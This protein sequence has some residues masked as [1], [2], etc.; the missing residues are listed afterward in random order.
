[1]FSALLKFELRHWFR[2]VAFYAYAFLLCLLAMLTVAGAGGIF[3]EGSS[4]AGIANAPVRLYSYALIFQKLLF[5]LLPAFVGVSLHRDYSSKVYS[6]LYTYPFSKKEYLPAK[7]IGGFLPVLVLAGL[8]LFGFVLG[9]LLPGV[10]LGKTAPFDGYAYAQLFLAYLA[11][12]LFLASVLVFAVVAI[13]RNV[14]AGFIT[15]LLLLLIREALV[16]LTGGLHADMTGVLADP[17]GET[18]IEQLTLGWSPTS[19]D[20]QPIP[21][22]P[23][24]LLNRLIWTAAALLGF[25]AI[26]RRFSFSLPDSSARKESRLASKRPPPL[27]DHALYGPAS[28]EIRL[29]FSLLNRL[30]TAWY[31]ARSDLR[32]ILKSG[33]FLSILVTGAL[34]IGVILLQKNPQTDTRLLPVTWNVLGIPMLFVTLLIQGLT[35][36]YAGMLVQRARAADMHVLIDVTPAPNWVFSLS[37]FLALAKMQMVLLAL[38]MATGISIQLYLG[39]PHLEPGHYLFDLIVI[40]L[41]GLLLWAVAAL[42]VQTLFT[43]PYLGLFVLIL[44]AAGLEKLSALGI[45]S[46]LFQFNQTPAPH[47]FLRYSDL[48][49]HDHGLASHLVY[50]G[51]WALFGVLLGFA[52]LVFWQRALV[53]SMS[54][55]WRLAR[56]QFN[57]R[58][59]LAFF[60]F[61]AGFLLVGTLLFRQERQGNNRQLSARE[62]KDYLEKFKQRFGRY[63]HTPQPRITALFF[64]MDLFP[65][66][67]CFQASGYFT[68]VNKS[69]RAMDTLL[70]RTGYDEITTLHLPGNTRL[71]DAD[72]VLKFGV[73]RLKEALFPGDSLCI[74]FSLQS[75]PNTML[76]RHSGVLRN[77]TH[78]KN[79]IFPRLGYFAE[80]EKANP[81]YPGVRDRHYQGLDAD[82][83]E[84]EATISTALSQTVIAPGDLDSS[85]TT[86][87]RR[88]FHFR[89]D[90]TIKYV[91]SI[92]SGEY[93]VHQENYNGVDLRIHHYPQHTYC[94]S[95][96]MDGLK[97]ALDYNTH[98]FG[99]YQHRQI[100]IVEF[101][102]SEGTYATTAANCIPISE[103]RFINDT[104]NAS[105][106]GVDIAFYVAGH[107]LTHQWWGNQVI[108]A[109]AQGALMLTES[110]TEYITAKLYERQYGKAQAMHFLDL[111]RNRYRMGRAQETQP[112]PALLFVQPEQSYL[113]YGKGALV[114][115]ALSESIG[116]HNLNAALCDFL[117]R[118]RFR[119]PP[120]PTSTDLYACLKS[121]TPDSLHN[122]LA[123]LFLSNHTPGL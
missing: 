102:R 88:Y 14:Y 42:F 69:S 78:L 12:N 51:Y 76:F 43:N 39:F 68:L 11:P 64:E 111:Q 112:E 79:D 24:L 123:Q 98:H 83:I 3:G 46:P 122:R 2:H 22:P 4:A 110:I 116:E 118:H 32:Y 59:A 9:T 95:Q 31:L 70:I 75:K 67:Q 120:Y 87:G 86:S 107:E 71:L 37:K 33:A 44:G 16:R 49:G 21:F 90:R 115:Y 10:E 85:W 52:T 35:F 19:L 105:G 1:M 73:Y 65:E 45:D 20:T 103:I 23:S 109:D 114:F 101:P 63:R 15:V 54:E 100:Q 104:G 92:L 56:E 17:F 108:P 91:F 74:A 30:K 93:A 7:F 48:N 47:F 8:V 99:S 13:S 61:L 94:L 62:E 18:A 57:G 58:F 60:L 106:N 81:Y 96:M 97:S 80:T 117:T 6:I 29:D 41:P 72:T 25:W 28:P 82:E 113:A 84:L 40:H 36:L 121:A 26:F 53:Q 55:R 66:T 77:G 27:P 50:K 34:L 5:L 119:G 38:V 89:P